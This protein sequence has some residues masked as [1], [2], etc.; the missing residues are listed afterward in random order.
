MKNP[1]TKQA[2]RHV[3]LRYLL[4]CTLIIHYI[5]GG[6]FDVTILVNNNE[7]LTNRDRGENR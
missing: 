1:I 4:D 5:R 2:Q 7:S 6:K 3:S